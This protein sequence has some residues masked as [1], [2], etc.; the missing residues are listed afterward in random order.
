VSLFISQDPATFPTVVEINLFEICSS[1]L[2]LGDIP[3]AA[4]PTVSEV[5]YLQGALGSGPDRLNALVNVIVTPIVLFGVDSTF[6]FPDGTPITNLAGLTFP[7]NASGIINIVYDVRQCSGSSY[8]VFDAGG[9]QI[10]YPTFVSLFHELSHAFHLA[11]R[12]LAADPEFQAISEEN[13]LRGENGFPLRDPNNHNGGCGFAGVPPDCFVVSAAYGSPDNPDV[14]KFRK[15]R[16]RFLGTSLLGNAVFRGICLE[17]Y[18]FAPRLARQM[19]AIPVLQALVGTVAVEPC[20]RFLRILE[21]YVRRGG[22]DGAFDEIVDVVVNDF[23]TILANRGLDE[24]DVGVIAARIA[25]IA[26]ETGVRQGPHVTLPESGTAPLGFGMMLDAALPYLREYL[27]TDDTRSACLVW[28]VATPITFFW[29]CL[30]ASSDPLVEPL[31]QRFERFV[32]DWLACA[33]IPNN[34]SNLEPAIIAEDLQRLASAVLTTPKL[35]EQLGRCLL[36]T[37]RPERKNALT[38]ALQDAGY[39]T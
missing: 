14:I 28:G 27:R 1:D 22:R 31:G 13:A 16:E 35:R 18:R 8:F 29:S 38:T 7:P 21:E 26:S 33:P 36:D 24:A 10:S 20:L 17:Y 4:D 2:G 3:S 37:S 34:F 19:A 25:A 6:I 9:T 23:K 30:V 15:L 11:Q 39:L 12:T 32:L 5:T